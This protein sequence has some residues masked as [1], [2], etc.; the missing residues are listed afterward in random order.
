[1]GQQPTDAG[2][3]SAFYIERA[4]RFERWASHLDDNEALAENFRLLAA[5]ARKAAKRFAGP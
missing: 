5:K 4:E 2:Q 1:M 3:D